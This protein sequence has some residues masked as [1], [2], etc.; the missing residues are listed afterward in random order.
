MTKTLVILASPGVSNAIIFNH[1]SPRFEIARVIIEHRLSRF[2]VFARR[3]KRLGV[4]SALGQAV[5]RVAIAPAL[6]IASR[7]RTRRIAAEHELN[8]A[9]IPAE[10]VKNVDS[11]NSA[12]TIALLRELQSTIVIV[13]GTRILSCD[14]LQCTS[15]KFI[16]LHA[17]ITPRY[18]GVHGAYWA[19]VE[20]RSDLCG[21]TLHQLD[22]GIDTGPVLAQAT[23]RPTKADNFATYP[24]LQLAASLPL[25][26]AVLPKL[27]EGRQLAPVSSTEPSRLWTHPTAS[28]YISNRLMRGVK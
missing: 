23:I 8:S 13:N 17:G 14:V 15:A 20:G 25:L 6:E 16:N 10:L 27:L 19:L 7:G 21:V 2:S 24:M 3:C 1:L 28:E 9:P 18:R 5:F 4:N 11:A 26:D 22:E 12:E